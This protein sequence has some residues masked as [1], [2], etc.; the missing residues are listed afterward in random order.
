MRW[1]LAYVLIALCVVIVTPLLWVFA[2][3][4][5]VSSTKQEMVEFKG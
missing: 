5:I 1:L 4:A 3:I 2:F